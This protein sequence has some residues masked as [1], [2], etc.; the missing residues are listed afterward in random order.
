[1]QPVDYHQVSSAMGV[2]DEQIKQLL[3]IRRDYLSS[4]RQ[5][6]TD[7]HAI[8]RQLQVTSES[9]QILAAAFCLPVASCRWS[10]SK[11]VCMLWDGLQ[12]DMTALCN[13]PLQQC[14][15]S[16]LLLAQACP[17][18]DCLRPHSPVHQEAGDETLSPT[19]ALIRSCNQLWWVFGALPCAVG[20]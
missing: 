4:V 9:L 17:C 5:L 7:R 2:S 20:F 12:S 18:P 16:I 8:F 15:E 14:R 6:L 1:M 10:A 3:D 11:Q 13:V 19:S